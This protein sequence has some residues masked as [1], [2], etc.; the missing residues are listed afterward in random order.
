MNKLSDEQQ[1]EQLRQRII[2]LGEKS[3]KKSYYPELQKQIKEL[4][5]TNKA[6]ALEI[7]EHRKTEQYKEELEAQLRHAQKMDAIGTLA[8]GIAHDFNNILSAII[9][10]AELAMM[11]RSQCN[12]ASACP[13]QKDLDGILKSADRARQLVQQILSFSSRQSGSLLPASLETIVTDTLQMLRALIPST[14]AIEYECRAHQTGILADVTQMHQVVMNLGTNAFHAL[15]KEGGTLRLEIEEQTRRPAEAVVP[16]AQPDPGVYVT[17]TVSDTGCGMEQEVVEKIFDPYFTT[18]SGSG[19]TGLGL[20][21]VHGIVSR[22]RGTITVESEKGRGT[23][24]TL[25][26]PR[27]NLGEL[28]VEQVDEGG[29]VE[30][31]KYCEHLLVIDDEKDLVEVMQATLTHLGYRVTTFSFPQ[32]AFDF[33]VENYE[34]I[35]L[36]ITDMNMPGMTGE[37][38]IGKLRGVC[39]DIPLILCTGFSE[40][41]QADDIASLGKARYIMK[42]VTYRQVNAAVRSLLD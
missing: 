38:L 20:A 42:P 2:G 7:A 28:P 30:E 29:Q 31:E 4:E 14:I 10:Y 23:T 39:Q 3:L 41:F 11:H 24:F 33:F 22:H 40:G 16:G 8:G 37:Q 6:L 1:R 19:G 27:L 36:V 35:D 13:A 9:G 12:S 25:S 21:T 18:K 32:K 17:L 26:F 15:R 5:R 34:E